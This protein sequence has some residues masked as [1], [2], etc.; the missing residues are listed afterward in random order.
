M[1]KILSVICCLILVLLVGCNSGGTTPKAHKVDDLIDEALSTLDE[2]YRSDEFISMF[3]NGGNRYDDVIKELRITSDLTS[4]KDV[5]IINVNK[6]K[7]NNAVL[8]SG[9]FNL[10]DTLKKYVDKSS[11]NSFTSLYNLKKGVNYITVHSILHATSGGYCPEEKDITVYLYVYETG[12]PVCVICS[13]TNDGYL[14]VSAGPLYIDVTSDNSIDEIEDVLESVP[15]IV[16]SVK[17]K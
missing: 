3:S 12:Y 15:N 10:S 7:I 4:P 17:K 9:A 16:D 5:Y 6:E 1:K 13:P 8:N 11:I 14:G 2:M